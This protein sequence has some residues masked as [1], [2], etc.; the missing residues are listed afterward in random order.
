MTHCWICG[1]SDLQVPNTKIKFTGKYYLQEN[2]MVKD[3]RRRSVS[4]IVV[5]DGLVCQ[6]L[7]SELEMNIF[8]MT[9]TRRKTDDNY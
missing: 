9:Q 3:A 4:V 1:A 5:L 7:R 6:I 8:G 2:I